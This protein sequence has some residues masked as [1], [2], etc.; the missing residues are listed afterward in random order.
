MLTF[1]N[2]FK[3]AELSVLEPNDFYHFE[4]QKPGSYIEYYCIR[5]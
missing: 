2:N 5:L 1:V 4:H 3:E